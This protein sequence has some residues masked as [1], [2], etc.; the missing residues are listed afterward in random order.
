[1]SYITQAILEQRCGAGDLKAWTDDDASG[2]ADAAV[3]AQAITD[4]EA[5]IDAAAGQHYAV[6]LT[7]ANAATARVIAFYAGSIARYTLALR[8][9]G[10]LETALRTDYEDAVKWLDQLAAGTVALAGETAAT[11][12]NRPAGGVVIAGGSQIVGRDSMDGM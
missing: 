11:D 2:T 9:P 5:R 7:L 4:A 1:M 3:I 8:R 10:N 12:N 6:P